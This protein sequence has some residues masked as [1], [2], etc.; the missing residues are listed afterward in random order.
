MMNAD[1]CVLFLSGVPRVIRARC[2]HSHCPRSTD[3][4]LQLPSAWQF[5]MWQLWLWGGV[6]VGQVSAQALEAFD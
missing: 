5:Y 6:R 3:A 2:E 1:V 4:R